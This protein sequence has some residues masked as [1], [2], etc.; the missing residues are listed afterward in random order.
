MAASGSESSRRR[1]GRERS[2]HRSPTI[3]PTRRVPG[4]AGPS[5]GASRV[6]NAS[7]DSSM[8]ML[9]VDL[10]LPRIATLRQSPNA[11][12]PLPSMPKPSV[13]TPSMPPASGLCGPS[14]HAA[15]SSAAAKFTTPTD[16]YLPRAT[17]DE[18]MG[19]SGSAV[20]HAAMAAGGIGSMVEQT[21]WKELARA[22]GLHLVPDSRDLLRD[23][24]QAIVATLYT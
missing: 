19:T 10:R 17:A 2:P 9:R 11:V 13:K 24:L 4:G 7:L 8:S 18:G 6:S 20:R 14:A 22:Y 23:N 21:Q 1:A 5:D 3:S 16:K 15:S 12:E